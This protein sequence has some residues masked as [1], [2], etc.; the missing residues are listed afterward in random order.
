MGIREN[1][2]HAAIDTMAPKLSE[3]K[4]RRKNI[5]LSAMCTILIESFLPDAHQ[6]YVCLDYMQ[7]TL[8]S[9]MFRTIFMT[10]QITLYSIVLKGSLKHLSTQRR[11]LK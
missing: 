6:K 7:S 8:T 1:E 3:K 4:T 2:Y 11:I 5:T 9:L 10:G